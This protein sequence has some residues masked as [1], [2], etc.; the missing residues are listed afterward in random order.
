M[1]PENIPCL[2]VARPDACALA[3]NHVLD[4]GPDGLEETVETLTA[5]RIP[6][7]GAGRDASD[8]SRPTIVPLD[9]GRVIVFSF[10]TRSSGIPRGWV[11]TGDRAGVG[12]L[13]D[14]SDATAGQ[15]VGRVR[16][17]KRPG[18]VVVVSLHWGA[19]WGYEVPADH[20]GFAHRLVD[21][22]HR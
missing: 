5:A 15:V 7:T 13:T 11:A 8:A 3:N 18:D 22:G 1:A 4:F 20:I 6:T 17:V 21:G 14:L 10:G 2:A 19:N 12:L 9:R 16:Q